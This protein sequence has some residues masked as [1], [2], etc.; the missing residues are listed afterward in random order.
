[1]L[2][3][4]VHYS[5]KKVFVKYINSIHNE[6]NMAIPWILVTI[7]I[8]IILLAVLVIVSFRKTKRPPDY[9]ALFW[10]GVFWFIIG[11]PFG[12][13]WLWMLGI[14][15]MVIGLANR[16]KWKKNRRTWEQVGKKERKFMT[17]FMIA[18]LLIVLVGIAL[19]LLM[20][21]GII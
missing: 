19:L 3:S 15:F 13:S 2:F 12:N 20:Q 6:H 17:I 7:A 21:K 1:M 8:M 14:V 4:C 18:I 16:K 5:F 10:V 9:Y 11:L